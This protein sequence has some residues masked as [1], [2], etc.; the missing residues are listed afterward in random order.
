MGD[1]IPLNPVIVRDPAPK[2]C[3]TPKLCKWHVR[4]HLE[5]RGKG[6]CP[7]SGSDKRA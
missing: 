7:D 6:K 5:R 1:V 4:C 2:S 3:R